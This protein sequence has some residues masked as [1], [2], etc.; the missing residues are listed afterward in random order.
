LPAEA[1]AREPTIRILPAEPPAAASPRPDLPPPVPPADTTAA[2]PPPSPEA[3]PPPR[4][5]APIP[6]PARQVAPFAVA[7]ALGPD[8]RVTLT[9]EPAELG[10]VEVSIE[11]QGEAA[12]VRVVA[13]RPETLALLQRDGRELERALNAAG[14]GGRETSLSFSLGGDTPRDAPDRGGRQPRAA[15][16][17]QPVMARAVEPSA[18]PRSLIDI[19]L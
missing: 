15:G 1:S 19:A 2:P 11:R 16:P 3:A 6:I 17:A 18:A 14:L 10:Q 13:E 9:L 7:L 12:S 5:A 8:A 4:P